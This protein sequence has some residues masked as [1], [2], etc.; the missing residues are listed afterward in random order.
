MEFKEPY[1]LYEHINNICKQYAKPRRE[2]KP[3]E[4]LLEKFKDELNTERIGSKYRPVSMGQLRR[5][6]QPLSEFDL[7]A[8]FSQCKDYQRRNGSFGRYFWWAIKI[9]K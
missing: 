9:K 8:F 6:L 2:I 3:R 4:E 1:N 7:H 5:K